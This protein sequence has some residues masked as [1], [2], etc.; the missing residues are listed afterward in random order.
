[1]AKKKAAPGKGKR[2]RLTD[3][4]CAWKHATESERTRFLGEVIST[5]ETDIKNIA[6]G[7]DAI[8]DPADAGSLANALVV[9]LSSLAP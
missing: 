9:E 2:N 5:L 1:M 8:L 6:E 7:M 4:R 3:L